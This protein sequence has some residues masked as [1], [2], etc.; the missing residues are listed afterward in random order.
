MTSQKPKFKQFEKRLV[1]ES[2]V[3][4]EYTVK[5]VAQVTGWHLTVRGETGEGAG[6]W[7]RV[8]PLEV[9]VGKGEDEPYPVPITNETQ[10]AMKGIALGGLVVAALCWFVIIGAKIFRYYKEKRK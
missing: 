9:I 1:G 5:P 6:A 3:V 7:L 4:G 2:V 10:A 8:T